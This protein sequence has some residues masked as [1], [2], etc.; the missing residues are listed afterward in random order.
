MF[1]Y[2]LLA[3]I[4]SPVWLFAQASKA[5]QA[6]AKFLSLPYSVRGEAMSGVFILDAESPDPSIVFYNPA[7]T[8]VISDKTL[9][10]MAGSWWAGGYIFGSVYN[11]PFKHGNLSFFI[12]GLYV[13][14][15]ESYSLIDSIVYN[16]EIAYL[17]TQL[18]V[19]YS[20]FLTD[21]FMVGGNLKILY[22]GYGGYTT[23]YSMAMDVGTY[24]YTGFR[25]FVI[26]SS[27]RHFGFD[28]RLQGTYTRYDYTN[29]LVDTTV[30][31]STYKLPTSFN[32]SFFGTVY[33]NSISRLK[34]GIELNHPVDNIESYNIGL[35]YKILDM[36]AIRAGY[37]FY[38]DSREAVGGANGLT[39]GVGIK[40]GKFSVDYGYYNKGVLPPINQ[41][42]I[43][44][45]F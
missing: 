35:E 10:A 38:K 27:I 36:V 37:R 22:E 45:K 28:A 29:E 23:A 31:Y 17:A 13:G 3:L 30:P 26:G 40:Y 5:G 33:S 25:D 24:Y 39:L 7:G 2:G 1:R 8:A 20:T 18:G 6:G 34:L 32:I 42:G 14:G 11:V 44:Y 43:V 41:I 15:I 4:L 9:Y 21:K 19:G 16:G 12:S